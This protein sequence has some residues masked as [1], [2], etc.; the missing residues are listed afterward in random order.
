MTEADTR[1]PEQAKRL[2]A[3][4]GDRFTRLVVISEAPPRRNTY[5][6]PVRWVNCQCDCGA[7]KEVRVVSLT[8]GVTKSCGC[9]SR[10]MT[11]TRSKTHGETVGG[12]A[13]TEHKIWTA[14]RY[15]CNNP[16]DAS[17]ENYG[18]RGITVC[19][20][21][22]ESFEAF[23]ADIGRR[24]S[25]HHSIDRIDND[26]NYEPGNV[27]W[28]TETEQG[29]NKRNNRFV[30]YLGERMIV[31]EACRRAGQLDRYVSICQ[32]VR[33]GKTFEEAIA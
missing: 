32:M 14:M 17:Y 15:R 21:W 11:S 19:Q 25:R 22:D 28:A 16:S 12:K 24:P 9:L 8:G 7:T 31:R 10:E 6:A 30:T 33:N 4:P 20:R 13:S 1:V 5:G 29:Q 3:Q 26:G 23:L 18:G 2:N 27:R